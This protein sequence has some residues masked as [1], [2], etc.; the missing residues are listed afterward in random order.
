[1]ASMVPTTPTPAGARAGQRRRGADQ[2]RRR[3]AGAACRARAHR[4]L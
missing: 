4:G 1:M 2:P 3:W